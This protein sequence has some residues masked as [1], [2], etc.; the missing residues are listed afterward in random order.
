MH[1]QHAGH[2]KSYPRFNSIFTACLKEQN[3]RVASRK[4]VSSDCPECIWIKSQLLTVK[5]WKSR[6]QLKERRQSHRNFNA[7]AQKQV[8][9]NNE[10]ACRHA[11]KIGVV[12]FDIMDQAK[13]YCPSMP[14]SMGEASTYKMKSKLT[15]FVHFGSLI[16]NYFYIALP[17]VAKG[18]N[19]SLT[20]WLHSIQDQAPAPLA[21]VQTWQVDGGAENWSRTIWAFQATMVEDRR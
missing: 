5:G 15:V 4:K 3:V 6:K 17:F 8:V 20:E 18:A 16:L 21:P 2:L 14:D 7:E 13:L 1:L 10:E 12:T 11:D 19:L 9:H